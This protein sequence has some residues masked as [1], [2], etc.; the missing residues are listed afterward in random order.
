MHVKGDGSSPDCISAVRILIVNGGRAEDAVLRIPLFPVFAK[1]IEPFGALVL[2]KP[3]PLDKGARGIDPILNGE[4][5][6]DHNWLNAES[7]RRLLP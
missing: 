6:R 3:T 7:L 5:R 1:A 2:I 4:L